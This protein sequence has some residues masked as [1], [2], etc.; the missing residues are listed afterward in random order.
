MSRHARFTAVPS[1][2]GEHTLTEDEIAAG[3]ARALEELGDGATVLGVER[4]DLGPFVWDITLSRN[5]GRPLTITLEH[6]AEDSADSLTDK[7]AAG[8][9]KEKS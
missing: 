2:Q 5:A 7:I 1:W 8:L 9:A 6:G 3:A 4:N